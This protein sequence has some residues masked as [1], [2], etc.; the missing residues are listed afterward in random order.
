MA[1]IVNEVIEGVSDAAKKLGKAATKIDMPNGAMRK[2]A[3]GATPIQKAHLERRR[4]KVYNQG[5]ISMKRP[6][7]AL[8][9]ARTVRRNKTISQTAPTSKGGFK[10]GSMEN[11]KPGALLESNKPL[12]TAY[13]FLGDG[14]VGITDSVKAY[15]Q[16]SENLK[17]AD[18]VW[19]A[20]KKAYTKENGKADVSRIAGSAMVV[21]LGARAV[22]GGGVTR[23]ANGRP[24]LA[25]I[26]FI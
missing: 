12:N 3:K 19:D 4:S 17:G 21:G 1:N 20:A 6:E 24:D 13:N 22:S 9:E 11:Y 5:D 26:P 25:G 14:V 23:D 16:N 18:R 10:R 7:A 8:Q 2:S 15:R